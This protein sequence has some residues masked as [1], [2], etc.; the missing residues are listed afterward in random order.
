MTAAPKVTI[1][2]G[3]LAGM[4][5]ALRLA[6]R[7]YQ[8]KLYEQKP[9]LGGNAASRPAAGGIGFDVYPHMYLP[10]Y[11]NFWAMLGEAGVDRGQAFAAIDTLKQL[12]RGEYPHFTG[13]K[14]GYS[15]VHVVQNLFSGVRPPADMFV[16]WYAAVDLLAERLNPTMLLDDV[17]VT[18]F[19]QARPYMTEDAAKAYDD[20]ITLVWAIPAWQ[21]A[22]NDYRDYL[23]Y[24]LAEYNPPCYLAK[25]SAQDTVIGPLTTALQDAGVDIAL[26]TEI[27]TVSCTNGRVTE[28]ALRHGT[29]DWTEPVDELLLAVPPRTLSDLIR[30]GTPGHRVVEAVPKLAE[31]ARLRSQYIPILNV[32]FTRKLKQNPCEPV[33]LTGSRLALG[34]TDISETWEGVPVMAN[35]TVLALSASDP[36]A[37]PDT[38][39]HD[40]GMAM[41]RELAEYLDFD[42][43]ASWGDSAD[44]DWT[45]THYDS[46]KDSELFL[47]ETGIDVWRPAAACDGLVNLYFAGN[48]CANRIG[49]MTVE[50]A[51][52]SGLEAVQAIV[53][54]RGF[55]APVDILE[56]SAGHELLYVWLRYACGPSAFAA[57]AWSTGTDAL[58]GLLRMLTP[59]GS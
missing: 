5:A 7:G 30:T 43:G 24:S 45:R 58:R 54:R 20:F 16:F 13:L 51:V 33:A 10:W 39:A 55:G 52:A 3:G 22:A 32:Y 57:K 34:Y 36:F 49:M 17:S 29:S 14:G 53:E 23:A 47:N 26:E 21:T 6:Q 37:L 12:R 48:F 44:I 46:N 4:T 19:L 40:N 50:S 42:P 15:P 28:I 35:R 2:G 59:T 9:M 18:G 8:V 38:G 41:L 1:A 31:L 25:G 11:R 27:T 56:P